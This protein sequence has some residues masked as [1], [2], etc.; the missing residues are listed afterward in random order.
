M[1]KNRK[2]LDTTWEIWTYDV[3]GN[4]QEGYDV[5]N[6]FCVDRGYTIRLKIENN[7]PNTPRQFYSSYPSDYQIKKA[8]GVN[9]R[10]NLDGNDIVIYV[11]RD[12]DY[13]PIGEM[14]LTSHSSLSPI[15]L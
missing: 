8:F 1:N 2:T 6:R 11:N 14:I 13:Y 5:N 12:S 9:C 15:R 4:R 10:L 3:W 7:N